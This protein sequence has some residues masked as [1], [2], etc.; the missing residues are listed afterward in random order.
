VRFLTDVIRGDEAGFPPCL[1]PR[2][3]P[4]ALDEWKSTLM[5]RRDLRRV[6]RRTLV[7]PGP[8]TASS[9]TRSGGIADANLDAKVESVLRGMTLDEKVGQLVG[10]ILQGSHGPGTGRTDYDDMIARGQIGACSMSVDPHEKFNRYQRIAMEKSRL[11]FRYSS[12]WTSFHGFKT[13]SRS[14]GSGPRHGT[15]S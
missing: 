13:S 9:Q 3:S 11:Q 5:G 1:L 10:S 7:G 4:S 12:G 8:S 15:P 6:E 2:R 14:S